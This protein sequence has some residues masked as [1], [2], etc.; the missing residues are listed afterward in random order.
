VSEGELDVVGIGNALVDVLSHEAEPFVEEHD[1]IRGSMTLIESGRAEELYTAMG[2]GTEMSGGSAAN[3]VAGI[4]SLGGRAAYIGRVYDDQLGAVFAHDLQAS[5]VVFRSLPATDGPPTGRCLIVI[6]PD[7]E[8]TMST[9]LGASSLLGPG[10]LDPE[11]IAA[12]KVTYLEGYL[13][14]RPEAK[15]A[16]RLATRLAHDAGRIAALTLSDSFCVQRHRTEW[17]RLIHDS[18]DIVFANEDEITMLYES[19]SFEQAVEEVKAHC[20]I[21]CL[22][23]GAEGS[24]IVTP[25]E[26]YTIAAQPVD[27][28]ID[29]TGAGDLYAAGFLY[30]YTHNLDL[31]DCGRLASSAA[32][33]VLGHTGARPEL[34]LEQLSL[35][36]GV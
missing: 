31:P 8:R 13:W 27:K 15:E 28:V 10:N 11:L 32:A 2:P 30:G 14:D 36:R 6:T 9:Y 25:Q 16:Y 17:R 7:G 35:R 34:S 23:R 21:A 29:T 4:A 26:Q 24:V 18:V 20:H 22:T 33:A 19:A 5:G 3:T 1:L 12:A